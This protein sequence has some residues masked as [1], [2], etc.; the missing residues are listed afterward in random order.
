MYP[1]IKALINGAINYDVSVS[2]VAVCFLTRV[3]IIRNVT[4]ISAFTRRAQRNTE[5]EVGVCRNGRGRNERRD[6][7]ISAKAA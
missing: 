4:R 5:G 3:G 7:L 6:I 2:C 1:S